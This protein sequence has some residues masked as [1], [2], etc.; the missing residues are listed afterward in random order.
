MRD[1]LRSGQDVGVHVALALQLATHELEELVHGALAGLD[2]MGL[3]LLEVVLHGDDVLTVVV[4]ILNLL[5]QAMVDP[6]AQDVWVVVLLDFVSRSGIE[7]GCLLRQQL[8]M[9][10]GDT[11]GLFDGFGTLGCPAL[12]L[13]ALAL[14]LFVQSFEDGEHGA[15][16]VLFGIEM[17]VHHTLLSIISTYH[18]Q[19]RVQIDIH[20]CVLARM[21]SNILAIPPVL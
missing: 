11:S 6:A 10:L 12:Y 9:L 5:V 16:E 20:T 18:P 19:S 4:L 21:F 8:D 3:E 17:H 7:G 2:D 1:A 14:D 15:L 13:L